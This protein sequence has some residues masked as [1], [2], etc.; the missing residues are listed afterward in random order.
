VIAIHFPALAVAIRCSADLA[1][2]REGIGTLKSKKTIRSRLVSPGYIR[3]LSF[4]PGYHTSPAQT[5]W[6]GRCPP[7]LRP[8]RPLRPAGCAGRRFKP[9]ERVCGSVSLQVPSD[10]VR[11]AKEVQVRLQRAAFD[12]WHRLPRR[13]AVRSSPRP[14]SGFGAQPAL[15]W[16]SRVAWRASVRSYAEQVNEVPRGRDKLEIATS[17]RDRPMALRIASARKS[18]SHL[19][20]GGRRIRTLIR[21]LGSVGEAERKRR[22]QNACSGSTAGRLRRARSHRISAHAD[23]SYLR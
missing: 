21:T 12:D 15:A 1:D 7:R 9:I 14:M 13:A 16:R 18:G 22:K 10:Q 2:V 5:R 11:S 20:G 8:Q 6:L 4:L 23:P 19:A 17:P 3:L